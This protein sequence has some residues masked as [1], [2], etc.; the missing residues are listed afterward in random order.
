MKAPP[1]RIAA[2]DGWRGIAILSVM[3]Y[4]MTEAVGVRGWHIGGHGVGIF[5]VLSGFLITGNLQ[6]ELDRK[7]SINLREFYT[8]RVKRLMPASWA[9]M[10]LA[11]AVFA[12][13]PFAPSLLEWL[14]ALTFWKNYYPAAGSSLLVLNHFW[15]LSVE[16]QFYFVWPALLLLTRRRAAWVAAGLAAVSFIWTASVHIAPYDERHAQFTAGALLVGCVAA[17]VPF[18]VEAPELWLSLLALIG[19]MASYQDCPLPFFEP[20]LIAVLLR[21]SLAAWGFRRLLEFA[22]LVWLGRISYS[23]YLWQNIFLCTPFHSR[24]AL[25]VKPA[26]AIALGYL[27]WRFIEQR[28]WSLNRA[29][30]QAPAVGH[31]EVGGVD[32]LSVMVEGNSGV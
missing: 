29:K 4:H 8:R 32:G 7:G 2:L 14:S 25:V 23:V 22:P 21:G 16:E 5:F 13:T 11:G 3:A 12:M 30:K 31:L 18:E 24:A 19:V 15:T 27:S 9:Y 6:R 10:L 1:K 28:Q 20:V 26:L 17:L